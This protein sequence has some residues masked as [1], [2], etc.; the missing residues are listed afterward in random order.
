MTTPNIWHRAETVEPLIREFKTT[1]R[2][3]CESLLGL[4]TIDQK[5]RAVSGTASIETVSRTGLLIDIEG[6]DLSQFKKNP[7]VLANHHDV[8][9]STLSPAVIAMVGSIS[10]KG[11]ALEFQNMTFDDDP[12]SEAWFQKVTKRFVRMVSVGVLPTEVELVDRSDEES[13]GKGDGKTKKRKRPVRYLHVKSSELLEISVTPIGANRGAYIDPPAKGGESI[14]ADLRSVQDEL[15]LLRSALTGP[16]DDDD[17]IDLDFDEESQSY[18]DSGF[19]D[20]AFIVERGAT[21]EGGKTPQKYRHL[22]HHSRSAKSPAENSTVDIPHL[23]NALAR[24]GQVKPVLESKESYVRRA[25]AHLEAHA[26]I[27]L[28]SHKEALLD[29]ERSLYSDSR[30][31]VDDLIGICRKMTERSAD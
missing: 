3:C 1:G 21:K 13:D 28:K 15:D 18:G 12:L 19:P 25:R 5:A 26:R 8:V 29:I 14:K 23:R 6:I 30:K 27:L 4:E 31:P 7:I 17:D 10:K 11:N 20:A 9:P 2:L 22:P 16:F 24:I